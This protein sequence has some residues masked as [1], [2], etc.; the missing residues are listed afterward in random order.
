M[1]HLQLVPLESPVEDANVFAATNI[2]QYSNETQNS[3][4]AVIP[5]YEDMTKNGE[6]FQKS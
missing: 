3:K 2:H 6:N 1:L 4:F 5:D